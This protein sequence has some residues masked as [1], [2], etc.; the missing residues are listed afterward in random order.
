MRSNGTTGALL[1][2]YRYGYDPAGNRTNEQIDLGVTK[3]IYNNLNQQTNT[4]GGGPVRFAGR[5]DERATV[6]LNGKAATMGVQNT[7]FVACAD[8]A[9]GTNTVTLKA[10]DYSNNTRTNQYQ[11]VVTN[12]GVA[13][14]LSYDL[15]GNLTNV[16][17]ATSTNSY[18]WD[19]ANRLT[20][21]TQRSSQNPAQLISEFTY[22]GAGR[23]ARIVEKTNAAVQSDKRFQWCGTQLCEERDSTGSNV[24]KRFFGEGEQI[25]G[26]NYFFTRD[27][28]GSVREIT[29]GNETMRARHAF[30]PYGRSIKVSGDLDV[31]F[32]FT[33]HYFHSSSGLHLTL[34]RA[35]DSDLARWL[36]RDPIGGLGG[37]NLYRYVNGNPIN[38]VDPLGLWD[39]TPNW[40]HNA[41]QKFEW[42]FRY[43][44]ID[45][46]SPKWGTMLPRWAHSDLHALG[47]D[48]VIEKFLYPNGDYR[49]TSPAEF[50]DFLNKVKK[51]DE[52]KDIY[53]LGTRPTRRYIP[54]LAGLGLIGL[55]LNASASADSIACNLKMF[56]QDRMNGQDDWAYVD[57]LT[58]RHELNQMGL[59]SGDIAMRM[60][61]Y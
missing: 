34:F 1:K 58:V 48:D 12:N 35:Y 37:I 50:A 56:A 36:S 20:K 57:A 22:D 33:G 59:F 7:N 2:Q 13:R 43:S 16:V 6:Q 46:H 39:W 4:V 54:G 5:L 38:S 51:M 31:D 49:K 47:F 44:G 21:I 29:D 40:H 17:T 24:T 25:S 26:A 23:R 41:M 15:N 55:A 42:E 10:T 61:Y 30:D 45:I 18:E 52:F 27:H 60:M 8:T 28:L 11:L 9:L 3:A 32:A 53:K 14:A 19:A